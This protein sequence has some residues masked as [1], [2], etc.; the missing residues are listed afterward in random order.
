MGDAATLYASACQKTPG[1]T[2][3]YPSCRCE[4]PPYHCRCWHPPPRSQT[5]VSVQLENAE[6]MKREKAECKPVPCD[7]ALHYACCI[8]SL[9]TL[10]MKGISITFFLTHVLEHLL[11]RQS[12]GM[13]ATPLTSPQTYVNVQPRTLQGT[14]KCGSAHTWRFMPSCAPARTGMSTHMRAPTSTPAPTQVHTHTHDAHIHKH[15]HA[16]TNTRTC[17]HAY[18][19]VHTRAHV[20]VHTHAHT[21]MCAHTH[22]LS[23]FL[24][25]EIHLPLPS[26]SL[27]GL[28]S[29]TGHDGRPRRKPSL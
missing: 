14:L 10:T 1:Q 3:S 11:A 26:T 20:Y 8:G 15:A 18:M 6:M 13:T 12:R 29:H 17:A 23:H 28:L 9:S 4:A 21:H 2:F 5:Q 24:W 16:H 22:R 27:L 19:H 25:E 7:D